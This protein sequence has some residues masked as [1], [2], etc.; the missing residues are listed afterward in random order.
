MRHTGDTHIH[1]HT[2][3]HTDERTHLGGQ[4]DRAEARRPMKTVL[5]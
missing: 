3:T 4:K 5:L 2:H 1:T